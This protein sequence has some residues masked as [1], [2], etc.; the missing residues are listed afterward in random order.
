M[1]RIGKSHTFIQ[2]IFRKCK[3]E[4]V[5]KY[6]GYFGEVKHFDDDVGIMHGEVLALQDVITFQG[7]TAQ[8]FKQAFR[9]SIDDYLAWCTERGE[10]PEKMYS[11]NIRL[12]MNPILH[13]NLALEA[14]RQGKSLNE[15]IN[16]KL[17]K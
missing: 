13:A 7:T 6:K 2:K 15:L 3:G 11:G 1:N 8:E 5:M 14:A 10:K 4:T 16:E 9:D 17:R 12:R